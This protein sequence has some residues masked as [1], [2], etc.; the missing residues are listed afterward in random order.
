MM[1]LLDEPNIRE[2]YAFAKSGKA[3]D[4]MMW[5]PWIIDTDVLDELN[6]KIIEKK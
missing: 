5:A 6:I 2:C 4:T 3:E 1:I